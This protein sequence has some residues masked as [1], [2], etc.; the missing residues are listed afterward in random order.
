[1]AFSVN[2]NGTWKT[3]KKLSVNDGTWKNVKSGWINKDGVWTKFYSSSVI[4]FIEAVGGGGGSGG[5]YCNRIGANVCA[6]SYGGGSAGGCTKTIDILS[7]TVLTITIGGGGAAGA[8]VQATNRPGGAG[9]G[10]GGGTSTVTGGGLNMNANG[11]GGGA[12]GRVTCNARECTAGGCCGGPGGASGGDANYTA[13]TG[14]C[15]SG[16][17]SP[18]YAI[19]SY[20]SGGATCGG[21]GTQGAVRITIPSDASVS[22]SGT[23]SITTVGSNNLYLFTGNGTM[24]FN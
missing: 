14:G 11:G 16:P 10:S 24:T 13:S 17:G 7:G 23:V 20:G 15:Y 21:A 12:G 22:T 4:T 9:A 5:T 2:D 1:M 19:S 6:C 8:S 3:V 18:G